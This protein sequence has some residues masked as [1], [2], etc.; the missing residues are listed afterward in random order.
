MIAELGILIFMI[1]E[2]RIPILVIWILCQNQDPHIPHGILLDG[3]P[4]YLTQSAK[5]QD[6]VR[7]P[8]TH[9]V[10]KLPKSLATAMQVIKYAHLHIKAC[11]GA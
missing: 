11:N 4:I 2:L 1:T 5:F 7:Y 3:I 9:S 6:F 10:P 8:S